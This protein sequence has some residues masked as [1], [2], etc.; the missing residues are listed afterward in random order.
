MQNVRTLES[1]K[2][3]TRDADDVNLVTIVAR[4]ATDSDA[5]V[6]VSNNVEPQVVESP[7]AV[8]V[9]V[10][11]CTMQLIGEARAAF[12][13]NQ[14]QQLKLE[15]STILDATF[16]GQH[17]RSSTPMNPLNL[18]ATVESEEPDTHDSSFVALYSKMMEQYHEQQGQISDD[19]VVKLNAEFATWQQ[20]IVD[21]IDAA[22]ET[23]ATTNAKIEA[24]RKSKSQLDKV[25]KINLVLY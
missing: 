9:E 23:I 18:D 6:N 14:L 11:Q 8:P 22:Q 21:K 2:E 19:D 1:S 24:T 17:I 15:Q 10:S 3:N 12:N 5:S 4:A 16:S 13:Q 25:S 20:R 7:S